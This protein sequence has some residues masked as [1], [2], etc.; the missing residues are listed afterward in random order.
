MS[1]DDEELISNSYVG[2][3]YHN[4]YTILKYLGKG[5]FSRLWI[6][7]DILTDNFRAMKLQNKQYIE[8]GKNEVK[9][10]GNLNH[11]N[12]VKI[13]DHFFDEKTKT[14]GIVLELLGSDLITMLDVFDNIP[15]KII[16]DVFR[17]ILNGV[18]ELH[19]RNI[20]HTDLKLE[21][22]LIDKISPKNRRFISFI[23]NN[24]DTNYQ[25]NIEE[26]IPEDFNSYTSDKKK[27]IKRR[28][29]VKSIKNI[30]TKL[31][32]IVNKYRNEIKEDEENLY[33]KRRL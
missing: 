17:Q 2:K 3:L 4:R 33:E 12:I 25:T 6:V 14:L 26:L 7:Y 15:I 24:L 27:K 13:Y 16:K 28:L 1:S 31:L 20:I 5:T 8:E 21:N 29:K 18:K 11:E 23:K 9:L 32:D 30:N 10:I 19:S 22:I